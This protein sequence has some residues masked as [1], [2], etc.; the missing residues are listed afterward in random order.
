MTRTIAA[1]LMS[2]LAI[3]AVGIAQTTKPPKPFTMNA[4]LEYVEDGKRKTRAM[5]LAIGADAFQIYSRY[6]DKK[7]PIESLGGIVLP[8]GSS[9]TVESSAKGSTGSIH[10]GFGISTNNRQVYWRVR[11]GEQSWVLRLS[12]VS[13]AE[14]FASELEKHAKVRV[15][16]ASEK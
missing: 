3:P 6:W 2:T 16:A 7:T 14:L 4:T 10:W 11:A 15:T 12:D 9:F 13:K 5:T 1:V 8:P